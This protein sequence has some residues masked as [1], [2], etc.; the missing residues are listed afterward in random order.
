MT[1]IYVIFEMDYTDHINQASGMDEKVSDRGQYFSILPEWLWNESA[2]GLRSQDLSPLFV[3]RYSGPRG[4]DSQTCHD[5][6]ELACIRSGHGYMISGTTRI[7]IDRDTI[8]LMPPDVPHI[9]YSDFT[10]D[11]IWVGVCGRMLERLSGDSVTKAVTRS[12]SEEIEQLWLISEQ[13]SQ[14]IGPELDGMVMKI[15]AEF[16]R[17]R[18]GQQR[19][20]GD[21]IGKA[22][23]YIHRHANEPFAVSDL[24]RACGCSEGYFYRLV[25]R[26]TGRTPVDLLTDVRIQRAV[27][28]LRE[29]RLSVSEIAR[30]VGY[31]DQFYFSRVFRK[32][33]GSPPSSYRE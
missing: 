2:M 13:R 17:V 22:I 14:A 16:L 25:N 28:L 26:R 18:S 30:Q 32:K 6:W 20:G 15:L 21:T 24:A 27:R 29:T 31:D 12:L 11:I 5:F 9:E 23:G 10:I 7:E 8:C 1:W 3:Q 4:T 33:T 19:G